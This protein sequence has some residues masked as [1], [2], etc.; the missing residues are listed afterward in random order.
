[1][2]SEKEINVTATGVSEAPEPAVGGGSPQVSLSR[3]QIP[4]IEVASQASS[5]GKTT[6]SAET[7]VSL[8]GTQYM[9]FKEGT[10]DTN[11][12]HLSINELFGF[13]RVQNAGLQSLKAEVE[14]LSI[15]SSI[16]RS[17]KLKS[18]ICRVAENTESLETG[19]RQIQGKALSIKSSLKTVLDSRIEQ[20][21]E[22]LSCRKQNHEIG[23][24]VNV[25]VQTPCWWDRTVHQTQ[26]NTQPPLYEK[27]VE[28]T[29]PMPETS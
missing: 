16:T 26:P 21:A 18:A 6:T 20:T 14:Q 19:K 9:G 7:V 25:E 13:L 11:K 2:K 5:T 17:D 27:S 1:M 29:K 3:S 12:L 28:A 23:E 24:M 22:K 10:D 4:G 8:P 15:L